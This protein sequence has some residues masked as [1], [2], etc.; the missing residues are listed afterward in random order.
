MIY[1]NRLLKKLVIFMCT[2]YMTNIYALNAESP[3]GYW[4]TIDDVTH[5]PKSIIQ[6][7]ANGDETLNGK[8]I[9]IFPNAGEDQNKVCDACK[10]DKHN[11]KIVGMVILHGMKESGNKWEGGEI[12]DP[13]NGKTYRCTFKLIQ[14]GASLEVRGYMGIAV[15]GR[16][17]IWQRVK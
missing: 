16:T 9:R 5:Q 1:I 4:K 2:L 7:Y 11:Q 10:G 3:V 17:Q 12:L 8:V 6:I 14:N 13:K 15:F